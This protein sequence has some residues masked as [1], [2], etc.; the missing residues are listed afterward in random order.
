MEVDSREV[1]FALAMSSH[2]LLL[3]F[4]ISNLSEYMLAFVSA[5]S[6][7]VIYTA[8]TYAK[9]AYAVRGKY[10][11]VKRGVLERV[12]DFLLLGMV[13]IVAAY[14]FFLAM[15]GK[16][17]LFFFI[18]FTSAWVMRHLVFSFYDFMRKREIPITRPTFLV[19]IGL[20]LGMLYALVCYPIM[21]IFLSFLL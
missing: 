20:L 13:A 17:L 1:L 19:P 3:S 12:S 6:L 4:F 10:F 5:L 9:R 16:D 21:E 7:P 11:R 14:A 2:L 18:G 15:G 8:K